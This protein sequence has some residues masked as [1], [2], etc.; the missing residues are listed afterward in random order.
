MRHA[1]TICA[2][3]LRQ[4]LRDRTAILVGFVVPLMLAGLMG[5]ALGSLDRGLRVR[6]ALVD[7]DHSSAS[8]RFLDHL[9]Q[10]WIADVIELERVDSIAS[11]ERALAD[12]R[13]DA[14][15]VIPEGLAGSMAAGAAGRIEVL[16]VTGNAFASRMA[17]GLAQGF[18]NRLASG[19]EPPRL[20][21]RSPGGR[22]SSLEFFGTSMAVL[23]LTFAVLSGSRA[24]QSEAESGTLARLAA[25]PAQ[26]ASILAGKFGALLLLGLLQMLV[27]I[28][29]TSLLFGSRWGNPV[30]TAALV[31]TSVLMAVG[32]S[33]FF[34]TV[35]GNAERGNLV[36]TF[37]IFLL[38]LV[39]GQFLPPAG[40]PDVFDLLNRLTP[41]GQAHRGFT[42]LIAAG[43]AGSLATILE[44]L[45]ATAGVGIAGIAFAAARAR[46]ALRR[47]V[48]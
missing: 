48:S 14:A 26:P 34:V 13:A 37:G 7:L 16:G 36:A 45:C 31:G 33:S 47:S 44:P 42:D 29:A 9:S 8:Q 40:L 43:E 18:A 27:M 11:A 38:A 19:T 30:P 17:R 15:I 25:T 23:F 20:R 2:K 6:L 3:D 39:G 28:G 35:A 46:S 1:L 41:N 12:D 24:L 22:L 5:L 21:A 32:L 10:A 4:R